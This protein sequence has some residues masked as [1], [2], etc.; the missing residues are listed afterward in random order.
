MESYDIANVLNLMAV[1][2]GTQGDRSFRKR[3]GSRAI[4][5]DIFAIQRAEVSDDARTLRLC[6]DAS[7]S[8][9][10]GQTMG[11]VLAEVSG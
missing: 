2:R 11:I 1:P 7:I 8:S 10:C 9:A 5:S 6:R 3:A 4:Q